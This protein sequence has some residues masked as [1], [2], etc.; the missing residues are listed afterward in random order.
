MEIKKR[1]ELF[2]SHTNRRNFATN[3]HIHRGVPAEEVMVFTNHKSLNS[4]KV[5]IQA[6]DDTKMDKFAREHILKL[7]KSA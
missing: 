2:A 5:Y 4:F 6:T 7:R 3:F 1:Y